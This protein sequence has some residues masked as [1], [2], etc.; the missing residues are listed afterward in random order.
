M[1]AEIDTTKASG[2]LTFGIFAALA[3]LQVFNRPDHVEEQGVEMTK[4]KVR[5]AQSAMGKKKRNCCIRF[6]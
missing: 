6:M 4:A 3:E 2:K 1:G 5:L